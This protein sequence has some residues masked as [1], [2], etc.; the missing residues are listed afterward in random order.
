[1][2]VSL[3][4]EA[5]ANGHMGKGRGRWDRK[6]VQ[7]RHRDA[8]SE[9]DWRDFE[10]LLADYYR[11]QGYEVDHV[12]TGGQGLA[13]DGGVDLRL[14]KD[15]K[16]TLVQCKRDSV[17]Q[18]EHNVVNELLGIKVNE[19]ADEAIVITS[20]EFTA[21]AR[22]FGSQGH[23]RL[24]DGVELRQML[25]H[26][27]NLLAPPTPSPVIA[28]AERVAWH[29]VDHIADRYGGR[30]SRRSPV[31]DSI[32]GLILLKAAVFAFVLFMGFV[33]VPMI[34]KSTL[35]PLAHSAAVSPKNSQSPAPPVS[36]PRARVA[37]MPVDATPKTRSAAEQARRDAEVK[38]Y[39]ERVPELTHYKYSPLDQDRQPKAGESGDD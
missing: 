21:A 12:G 18:T 13:F 1:V 25:G 36:V 2:Y 30:P 4:L 7:A 39:L 8:L 32:A 19:G 17:F 24:I 14:R 5:K 15:G 33:L 23:V 38:A 26:R 3:G 34:I 29:A 37:V 10:R 16:L 27:L 11:E 31:R 22:R 9:L 28:A 6:S 20:G 35:A